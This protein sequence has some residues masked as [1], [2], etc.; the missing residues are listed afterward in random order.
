M[1]E[2]FIYIGEENRLIGNYRTILHRDYIPLIGMNAGEG[3]E[4]VSV[5]EN[6]GIIDVVCDF[7]KERNRSW[8]SH[9]PTSCN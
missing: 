8:L 3:Y 1:Y 4:V 6:L 9:L 5:Y 2:L 7:P